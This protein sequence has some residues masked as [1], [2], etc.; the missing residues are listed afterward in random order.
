MYSF[1]IHRTVHETD[2]VQASRESTMIPQPSMP[3]LMFLASSVSHQALMHDAL[4][5]WKHQPHG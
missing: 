4:R 2:L 1:K 5:D 3:S